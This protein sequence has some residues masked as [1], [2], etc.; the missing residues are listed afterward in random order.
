M[1]PSM[2]KGA[3]QRPSL[4]GPLVG[5]PATLRQLSADEAWRLGQAAEEAFDFDEARHLYRQAVRATP[6]KLARDA[7]LRYATFLVERLGD[8]AEVAAWL[9]EG[10][11]AAAD[12]KGS[13][14]DLVRLVARAAAGVAHPRAAELDARLA[15]QGDPQA[16]LRLA[17][18]EMGDAGLERTLAV[19][20]AAESKLDSEGAAFLEQLRRQRNAQATESLAA[21]AAA[22][23]AKALERAASLLAEAEPRWGAAPAFQ[24]LRARLQAAQLQ[25]QAEALRAELDRLA[26][27]GHW[28]T[29][30]AIARQLANLSTA[31]DADRAW[32][33]H[34]QAQVEAAEIAQLWAAAQEAGRADRWSIL[35]SLAERG[36]TVVPAHA[37]AP[38][39]AAWQAVAE[40]AGLCRQQ[41][42]SQRLP[43]LAAVLTLRDHGA[44]GD[45]EELQVLLQRL[46]AEWLAAPVARAAAQ[47]V[48]QWQSAVQQ[49]EEAAFVEA[50]QL[51]IDHGELDDA[52]AA[53]SQWGRGNSVLSPL[54]K[55]VRKDLTAAR[56]VAER[57]SHLTR[58]FEAA[59]GRGAY[60][61]ARQVLSELTHLEP[62]DVVHALQTQL[63]RVAGPALRGMAVPPGL[64]KLDQ[65]P[66]ACAVVH[67]RLIVVQGRM[68]L[69]V[70][71]DTLGLQPFLL[72]EAWPI[73]TNAPVRLAAVGDAVRLVGLSQSR[74][75][76]VDQ[77][78][79]E[80]PH[81][82][83]GIDLVQALRGDDLLLGSALEP[84]QRQYVL[85]GRHSLRGPASTLTALDAK[86]LD[87]VSQQRTQPAL[88][89]AVGI[90]NLPDRLLVVAQLRERQNTKNF[91]VALTDGAGKP[92]LRLS[93]ADL[94]EYVAGVRGAVAW[95]EQDRIFARFTF[96]DPFDASTIRDEPS[97]LVLRQ[98]R[99]VF[100][101]SDLR[102]RFAP[103][104]PLTVDHAWALDCTSGR[105]WFAALP[106]PGAP[107]EDAL[108][109]GVDAKS[110]RADPA[111]SIP[112]AARVLSLL[113]VPQGAVAFCRMRAGHYSLVRVAWVNAAPQL[114]EHRLPL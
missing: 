62:G 91:A 110:L 79:G 36:A 19:L 84:D 49:A 63:D 27:A 85:L 83:G 80:P 70:V 1:T 51:M 44:D 69:S 66:V 104:E 12:A 37:S 53:L 59:L 16:V 86:T 103:L 108:L 99:V 20:Q 61:A 100:A 23:D 109:L 105:L 22:I 88:Q 113:A 48:A 28:P 26:D 14:R 39:Q 94:G 68:W 93:D 3:W 65:A 18:R 29:A 47:A 73:D 67:G 35:A 4:A 74:L 25:S 111:L 87:V 11:D 46:P 95:P 9:D 38:V 112:G 76:V 34:V 106:L 45:P 96:H 2:H 8:L 60:F 92:I 50:V 114:T 24:S 56:Q 43:A 82:Q 41:P 31:N 98:G 71:L 58:D 97:L 13:G 89:S 33:T 64:H 30:L 5:E 102:R 15:V 55:A 42:L 90:E 40:V 57:R 52:A 32:L 21:T 78:P 17:K 101:S 10:F 77:E 72:P 107:T 54:L 81:V 7:T 75:V 6:G